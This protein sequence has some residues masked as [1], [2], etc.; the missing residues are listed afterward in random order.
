MRR[1]INIP[2][3]VPHLGCP[4]QCS[5]CNQRSISG[6]AGFDIERMEE[7]VRASLSTAGDAEV[8]IA[9]FGGSFTG[10]ER[11]LMESIL[12]R[13]QPYLKS[14]A[15]AALR[16]ST[17][18]DYI[19][20]E[21]LDIL[22]RYGMKTVELGIQSMSDEVLSRCRRGHTAQDSMRAAS[23]LVSHG[24][25]FVGQMMI[26]LPG[27]TAESEIETAKRISALGATAARVYP[28]VV[29]RKTPLCEDAERGIY[30]PLCL[31]EAVKRAAN[32]VEVFR[33]NS[34]SVIR[35][36]LQQ[37]EMLSDAQTVYS[38]PV[39]PALG[40]MVE[41]ELYRRRIEAYLASGNK[42][43]VLHLT[44]ARGC[45]SA[46][47][48]QHKSNKIYLCRTYGFSRVR[49]TESDALCKGDIIIKT[50]ER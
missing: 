41:T 30:T 24:F 13:V 32:A 26:G 1:H 27:A 25:S 4:H 42:A 47:M 17:R 39:H 38:G 50:E 31:S 15:V 5:F 18:P 36:G 20:E 2:I 12:M 28:T 40:E 34:V 33:E 21:I 16:C 22:A 44:V 14:G 7:T 43:P 3:F 6:H 10:I 23:L 29:F 8:E 49:V 45:T 19:N 11:S 37:T 35:V 48:G 9:F 46:A